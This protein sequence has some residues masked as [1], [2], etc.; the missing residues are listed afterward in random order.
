MAIAYHRAEQYGGS[1]MAFSRKQPS[2]NAIDTTPAPSQYGDYR[3]ALRQP[4]SD[5]LLDN[6]NEFDQ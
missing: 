5:G 3:H 6:Q 2:A 4:T 1:R